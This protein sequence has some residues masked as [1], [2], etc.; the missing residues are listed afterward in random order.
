MKMS[1]PRVIEANE[2]VEGGGLIFAKLRTKR[3]IVELATIFRT[4]TLLDDHFFL[5]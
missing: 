4:R 1:L 5:S 3:L 2:K